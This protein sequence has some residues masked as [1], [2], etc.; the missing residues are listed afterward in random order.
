[1]LSP[2]SSRQRSSGLETSHEPELRQRQLV[3]HGV[4]HHLD[5]TIYLDL[6]V[7]ATDDTAGDH[8]ALVELHPDDVVRDVIGERPVVHLVHKDP[9]PDRALSGGLLPLPVVAEVLRAELVRG[10]EPRLAV[11]ALLDAKYALLRSI[12]VRLVYGPLAW[13]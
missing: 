3:G 2:N 10:E 13:K 9:G 1:M 12:P 5:A 6:L 8:R 7:R 4:E 11:L